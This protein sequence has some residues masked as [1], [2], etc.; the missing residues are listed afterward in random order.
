MSPIKSC[1]Q[2][3]GEVYND[4]R[5]I[6]L[7]WYTIPYVWIYKLR[8]NH[9]NE[10]DCGGALNTYIF[11][12][13]I[14]INSSCKS[15]KWIAFMNS[16]N[17]FC[18]RCWC[19]RNG[20]MRVKAYFIWGKIVETFLFSLFIACYYKI[21]NILRIQYYFFMWSVH[22]TRLSQR[23]N[24]AHNLFSTVVVQHNFS[25]SNENLF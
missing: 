5:L 9:K 3:G 16:I 12:A 21:H 2:R 11:Y 18:V 6:L 23:T 14:Y 8:N 4:Y 20:Y 17:N 1:E 13:K 24:L 25:T 22:F 7:V 10:S 15:N 19:E